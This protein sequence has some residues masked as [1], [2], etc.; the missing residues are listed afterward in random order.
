MELKEQML[1]YIDGNM[2]QEER[3][4]FETNLQDDDEMAWEV[5]FLIQSKSAA[6]KL[7]HQERKEILVNDYLK[8]KR[9]D[10]KLKSSHISFHWAILAAAAGIALLAIVWLGRPT[11]FAPPTTTDLF[12]QNFIPPEISLDR[13]NDPLAIWSEVAQAYQ[14]G[15]LRK[16]EELLLSISPEE[17]HISQAKI[18]LYLGAVYLMQ[19][20]TGPAISNLKTVDANSIFIQEA[21]WYLA[22]AYLKS[23]RLPDAKRQFKEIATSSNH[24]KQSEASRILAELTGE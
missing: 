14:T 8:K 3:I 11:V 19:N 13:A 16:C 6:R 9:I 20:K 22:L 15:D 23:N 4:L 17:A 10:N 1:A 2:R 12:A 7:L 24:Y 5:A 18:Q 21:K